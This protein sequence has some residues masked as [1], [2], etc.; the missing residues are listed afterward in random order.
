MKKNK[1]L[2][3]S[4]YFIPGF[5]AGGP[6]K[7]ILNLVKEMEKSYDVLLITRNHDFG[8]EKKYKETVSNRINKV[9]SLNIIYVD[10]I[11]IKFIFQTIKNFEPDIIHLNS[12]FSYFSIVVLI[13]KR[14]LMI[15][16]N[17]LLSPRGELQEN[18]LRIKSFKKKYKMAFSSCL[19]LHNKI[20]F[21]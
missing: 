20:N 13:L 5:K 16:C 19:L 15:P 4:D 11:K 2:F 21:H 18:A 7:S 1:I 14:F 6:I 12:F 3:F 10:D 8:D 17:I 9:G